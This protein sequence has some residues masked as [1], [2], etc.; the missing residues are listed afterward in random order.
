MPWMKYA[1][2][3]PEIIQYIDRIWNGRGID[4]FNGGWWAQPDPCAPP[5]SRESTSCRPYAANDDGC[6]YYKKTWGPDPN[7]PGD[8]IRHNGDPL[9]DGR[10]SK[11]HGTYT[12]PTNWLRRSY[13]VTG[14][15]TR[16]RDCAD[17][18]HPSYPCAGLGPVPDV[19]PVADPVHVITGLPGQVR[20]SPSPVTGTALFRLPVSTRSSLTITDSRGNTVAL[21]P[22]IPGSQM[23]IWEGEGAKPGLYLYSFRYQGQVFIGKILKTK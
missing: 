10:W 15:W 19:N 13:I 9:T 5:D 14:L 12:P 16:F 20:I 4:N 8:C 18:D 23:Y 2:N 17:P 7:K 11:Y 6:I 22:S 21:L 1:N 3:D